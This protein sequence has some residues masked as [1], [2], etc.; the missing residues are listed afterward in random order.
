M[1]DRRASCNFAPLDHIGNT[2]DAVLAHPVFTIEAVHLAIGSV[3]WGLG[4]TKIQVRASSG[5]VLDIEGAHDLRI[6]EGMCQHEDGCKCVQLRLSVS[7]NSPWT[8]LCIM[9]V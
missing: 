1:V 8:T 2:R 4:R 5:I 9:V 3:H 7:Q 6:A